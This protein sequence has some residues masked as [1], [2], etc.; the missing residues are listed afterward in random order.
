MCVISTAIIFR[1]LIYGLVLPRLSKDLDWG[2]C[3]PFLKH[4]LRDLLSSAGR[5]RVWKNIH[6]SEMPGSLSEVIC[7]AAAI[8][9]F[10]KSLTLLLLITLRHYFCPHVCAAS[11]APCWI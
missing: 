10:F 9:F 3:R 5:A 11:G 7:F 4:Q 1:K 8:F 2:V 6:G